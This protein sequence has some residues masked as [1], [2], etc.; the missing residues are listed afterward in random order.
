MAS[1]TL[2]SRIKDLFDT[3]L[4]SPVP[5]R[6]QPRRNLIQRAVLPVQ[7]KLQQ[8]ELARI[9]TKRDFRRGMPVQR[10][11][12]KATDIRR[13][14]TG[15]M[16]SPVPVRRPLPKQ[17]TRLNN[18]FQTI[19]T[20]VRTF[21]QSV[22][23]TGRQ[24][25]RMGGVDRQGLRRIQQIQNMNKFNYGAPF[26]PATQSVYQ[27]FRQKRIDPQINKF[28]IKGVPVGK[29]ITKVLG[30]LDYSSEE[31]RIIKDRKSVV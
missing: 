14:F 4:K 20:G 26:Q 16:L 24:M 9:S 13:Q 6:K 23:E 21:P 11:K 8:F 31:K 1:R 7:K 3:E 30:L 19:K 27:E 10:I 18:T 29:G 28:K 12:N 5:V 15:K 25:A 2:F 17:P 22:R